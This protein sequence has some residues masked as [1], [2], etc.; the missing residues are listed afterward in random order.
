MGR[1]LTALGW[2]LGGYLEGRLRQVDNQPRDQGEGG[3]VELH[4]V[5]HTSTE[6]PLRHTERPLRHTGTAFSHTETPRRHTSY[7]RTRTRGATLDT[8][9]ECR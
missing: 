6:R 1:T 9:Q 4:T 5:T 3:T 2:G 8:H 7:V